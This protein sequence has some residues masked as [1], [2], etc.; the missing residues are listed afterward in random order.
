[1]E[2][3]DPN[4]TASTITVWT[5]GGFLLGH[6]Y[7]HTDIRLRRV[8]A[9]CLCAEPK[10]RPHIDVLKRAIKDHLSYNRWKRHDGT[11]VINQ[12]ALDVLGHPP[13]P[14]APP[15]P[16]YWVDTPQGTALPP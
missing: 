13:G 3:K 5:Y 4:N 9:Q 7:R 10:H 11:P 2:I 12:W 14:P 8:V 6:R 16:P 15:V 1:M